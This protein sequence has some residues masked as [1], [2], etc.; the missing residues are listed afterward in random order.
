MGCARTHRKQRLKALVAALCCVAAAPSTLACASAPRRQLAVF[1]VAPGAVTLQVLGS[2]SHQG[3]WRRTGTS[4]WHLSWL[5]RSRRWALT[6][7]PGSGSYTF[8]LRS[9]PSGECG[10]WSPAVTATLP[11]VAPQAA[12]ADVPGPISCQMLPPDNPLNEDISQLPVDPRSTQYVDS[13]GAGGTLRWYFGDQPWQGIPYTVVGPSQPFVPIRFTAYGDQS[14]RGPYPVPLDAPIEQSSDRHVLT[15]QEQADGGCKDYELFNAQRTSAGWEADSGAVF[16]MSSDALRPD[17]WTSADAAGLPILP[18]LVRYDEVQSGQID[19]AL[20]VTVDGT[21]RGFIHPATHFS[22]QTTDP[23]LPPMGLRLRL[24][25]SFDL[26]AY[27]GAAL[28]ILTALKRYGM[29]VADNG[30]S[31]FISGAPDRRWD[32]TNLQELRTVPA[33]A[34]E[35]VD[36][37]PILRR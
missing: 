17:T 26:S 30:P 12:P 14:D 23:S 16:D 4:A 15:L 22:S 31:W 24:K 11:A 37:G 36:T 27:S 7:L 19:H 35:A 28:V 29:I 10:G 20:R 9:C 18:L 6:G 1:A 2:G 25:A 3:R 13:I 34:F 5:G 21:Q 8:Q 33:T 32:E